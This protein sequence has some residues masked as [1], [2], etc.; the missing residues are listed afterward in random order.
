SKETRID[1]N[2]L[3]RSKKIQ[4]INGLQ[5]TDDEFEEGLTNLLFQNHYGKKP[6]FRQII[7]HNIRYRDLS[8]N[9]TLKTLDAY[10]KNEE[11][12]TLYLFLLGCDFQ[13]GDSKQELLTKIRLEQSFK[14]RLEKEQTRSAYEIALSLL[15]EE[16]SKL[17]HRKS[18]FNLNENFES[19]LSTLNNIKFEISQLSSEIGRLNIRRSLVLEAQSDLS[20]N[21]ANIDTAQLRAIYE[22]AT[23]LIPEIQKTFDELYT[24]HNQM[25]TEKVLYI[26]KDLPRLENDILLKSGHLNRLLEAEAKITL[27]ISKSEPFEE[28][29]KIIAELNEK[30]HK[31]GEFE[32]IL[33]QLE[34]SELELAELNKQLKAIDDSLFSQ[35]YEQKIKDQVTKFNKYFST[36][37]QDLYDEQ[38]A[39][40]VDPEI[41]N[42]KRLYKFSAFNTNFSSGKK[43]GEISCFDIA[44]T[45]FADEERIPCFHFLLNDKKELMHDNQLIKIA[46]LVENSNIQFV[47]SILRDKLPDEINNEDNFIVKLSEDDKLFRIE[48]FGN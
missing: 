42:G 7:S 3:S 32:N 19:D 4:K 46:N 26:S 35:E 24:F 22:Q 16:I 14:T 1:R 2:F 15:N 6:T 17:N 47:A 39:L 8:I 23:T 9:N 31:K 12:E 27:S 21:V 33:L 38:Y 40:K 11:Y 13:D 29:E 36:V 37:S 28:L 44:Y 20:S 5:K 25:I 43:Q 30:H 48:N 34:R 10:T 41:K 45:L 18:T